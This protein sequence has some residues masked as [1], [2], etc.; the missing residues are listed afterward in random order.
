MATEES[1]RRRE[2][3]ARF[4][5]EA[6]DCHPDRNEGDEELASQRFKDLVE[7]RDRALAELKDDPEG[8]MVDASGFV[9]RYHGLGITFTSKD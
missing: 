8:A 9:V 1:N 4:R 2:I 7:Q 3:R 5:R 6:F